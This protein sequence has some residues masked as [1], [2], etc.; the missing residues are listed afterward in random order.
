MFR[1]SIFRSFLTIGMLLG[2][3]LSLLFTFYSHAQA[4][5]QF[6]RVA[7]HDRS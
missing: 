5:T 4:A 2:V 1:A 3:M 6:P 7:Q